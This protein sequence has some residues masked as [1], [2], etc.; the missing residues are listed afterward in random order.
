MEIEHRQNISIIPIHLL[1]F[2]LNIP[3]IFNRI[4]P[5]NVFLNFALSS[6]YNFYNSVFTLSSCLFL[7]IYWD[8]L[9]LTKSIFPYYFRDIFNFSLSFTLLKCITYSSPVA[10][11]AWKYALDIEAYDCI[12]SPI[13]VLFHSAFE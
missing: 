5:I 7:R 4:F 11:I 1:S 3:L 2:E 6:Y 13:L 8:C 9:I 10:P 12:F